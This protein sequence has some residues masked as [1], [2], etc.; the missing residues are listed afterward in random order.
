MLAWLGLTTLAGLKRH[1]GDELTCSGPCCRTGQRSVE[2][3]CV[4]HNW[5]FTLAAV[6]TM[7][8]YALFE[9]F[10]LPFKPVIDFS[11]VTCIMIFYPCIVIV[12]SS[13]VYLRGVQP[14]CS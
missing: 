7:H 13:N 9:I 5:L 8:Y 10:L 14:F 2:W 4:W 11:A 3:L 12:E 1:K 6:Y